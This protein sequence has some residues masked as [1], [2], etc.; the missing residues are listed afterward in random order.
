MKNP[1]LPGFHLPRLLL[2]AIGISCFV[3]SSFAAELVE[4]K[5]VN[6]GPPPA[7]A[8]VLFDGTD[9]SKWANDKGGE[10]KWT[11]KH[12]VATVNGTG[13]IHT[14][15]EFG[16]CQ[17]HL[18]WATPSK[19]KG[20][21]QGRGNSGV[22][23][24][25]LY[26]IQVLD[27]YNN[28]TYFDGQAGSVY[29]QYPPLVNVCRKPGEWQTYDIIYHAPRFAAD[30]KLTK[31]ATVTVLQNGILVQDHVELKGNTKNAGK[32]E[33]TAHPLKQPL[34]LQDH[35]NPVRYR[36]IWIREL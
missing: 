18:E 16:D 7:D 10:A 29:K 4:P 13:Y 32:A 3:Q 20:D 34:A 15:Q 35:G 5:V 31:P 25:N 14:K 2:T 24:Q 22:F 33:Y 21:G 6:P 11:V 19:I 12:G 17:L 23:M 30:G 26:E 8:I 36:N 9:L 1:L 27:S 28:K